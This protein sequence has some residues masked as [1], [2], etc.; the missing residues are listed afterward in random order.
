MYKLETHCHT[1][2]ISRCSKMS[3][4]QVV[5]LY[6]QNGYNG[7]FITEHF[8]NSDSC[9]VIHDYASADYK[10]KID[11]FCEGYLKVKECAKGILDV[12][13]GLEFSYNGTDLLVYG[14][15]GEKLKQM[16]EIMQMSMR[17]F[18][19]FARLN[20]ALIVHAHPFRE[21]SY[22]DHIRLYPNVEAVEVYNACRTDLCN[23]LGENY[24][25]AYGKLCCSGTDIHVA[26][27]QILSGMAFEEK[28]SSVEQFIKLVRE[29]KGEIIKQD[30]VLLNK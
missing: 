19:D 2:V 16:P 8:L 22:I 20:G 21:A 7:I 18:I 6:S 11:K 26:S 12:F 29:G 14:L 24:A 13:F 27:Q 3:P 28:I 30:N 25:K 4:S 9:R 10:T 23:M 15:D 1:N 17:D 5:E